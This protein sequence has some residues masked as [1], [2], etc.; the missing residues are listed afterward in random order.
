MNVIPL[1][2]APKVPSGLDAYKVYT[3]P[4]LDVMHLRLSPG[5]EVAVHSNPVDV[6]FCVVQ[7][8]VRMEADGKTMLLNTYDTVEVLAGVER[9]LKNDSDQDFRVLVLKKLV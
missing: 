9:G 1:S 5:D 7:G 6:V 8:T 2:Q 4:T 3:S